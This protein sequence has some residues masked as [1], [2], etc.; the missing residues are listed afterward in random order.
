MITSSLCGVECRAPT[1]LGG[2]DWRPKAVAPDALL[3]PPPPRA[4]A[5]PKH[6]PWGG[7]ARALRSG[8]KAPHGQAG[9]RNRAVGIAP[10]ADPGHGRAAAPDRALRRLPRMDKGQDTVP[11]RTGPAQL[12]AGQEGRPTRRG[13]PERSP[14]RLARWQDAQAVQG[15]LLR[16]PAPGYA[17]G[18]PGPRAQRPALSADRATAAAHAEPR[19]RRP[20]K[21]YLVSARDPLPRRGRAAMFAWLDRWAAADPGWWSMPS[22]RVAASRSAFGSAR[23]RRCMGGRALPAQAGPG[24]RGSTGSAVR[25]RGGGEPPDGAAASRGGGP[26][27]RRRGRHRGHSRRRRAHAL[28][29]AVRQVGDCRFH[30]RLRAA[31]HNEHLPR[32]PRPGGPAAPLLRPSMVVKPRVKTNPGGRAVEAAG[33]TPRAQGGDQGVRYFL[34]LGDRNSP[35][36]GRGLKL[37]R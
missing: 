9:R 33:A 15:D 16:E 13:G 1:P 29:P 20:A 11:P 2:R 17:E 37:P 18:L 19:A 34:R 31:H 3:P 22:G 35:R 30:R 8:A 27:G 4:E 23:C 32:R 28:Q 5:A 24:V 6:G 26:S 21:Y 12:D 14:D 10:W 25:R 36:A 7:G